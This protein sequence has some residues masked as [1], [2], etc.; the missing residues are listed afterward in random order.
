M[1]SKYSSAD[2]SDSVHK[3]RNEATDLAK[4]ILDQGKSDASKER[5]DN[6]NKYYQELDEAMGNITCKWGD[7]DEAARS[8][9]YWRTTHDEA[10][11]KLD[12]FEQNKETHIGDIKKHK[13]HIQDLSGPLQKLNL[14][15][16]DQHLEKEEEKVD[17]IVE[18]TKHAY[19]DQSLYHGAT[20]FS[21]TKKGHER[22]ASYLAKKNQELVTAGKILRDML[23]LEHK[24]RRKVTDTLTR[25]AAAEARLEVIRKSHDEARI[26]GEC[27]WEA[28]KAYAKAIGDDSILTDAVLSTYLC[29]TAYDRTPDHS[30]EWVCKWVHAKEK[31]LK[32]AGVQDVDSVLKGVVETLGVG[33]AASDKGDGEEKGEE[34]DD[35]AEGV[36]GKKGRKKGTGKKKSKGKGKGKK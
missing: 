23:G 18:V 27:K 16:G 11:L 12:A 34:G 19:D 24:L 10:V 2:E 22:H 14:R 9:V 6:I 13:E 15:H 35:E 32:A 20:V 8:C 36:E 26:H 1:E 5:R 25:K 7:F 4:Q 17:A 29:A 30:Y 21:N 3:A 31:V 28:I 33:E